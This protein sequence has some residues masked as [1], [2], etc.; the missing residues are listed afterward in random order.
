MIAI[1]YCF[2]CNL[3]MDPGDARCP[4]CGSAVRFKFASPEEAKKLPGMYQ[5][6]KGE[7]RKKGEYIQPR[8]TK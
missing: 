7:K 2:K 6:E 3:R 5:K 8:S 1:P 4:K